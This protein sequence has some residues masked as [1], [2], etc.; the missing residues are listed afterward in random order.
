VV[1]T[2]GNGSALP[3][4]A[5]SMPGLVEM[6]SVALSRTVPAAPWFTPESNQDLVG[7]ATRRLTLFSAEERIRV[8]RPRRPRATP[9]HNLL[10]LQGFNQISEAAGRAFETRSG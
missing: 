6:V 7:Q 3:A 2:E 5:C 4:I 10:N 9:P 1:S 8:P